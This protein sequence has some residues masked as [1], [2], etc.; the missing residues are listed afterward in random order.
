M[1]NANIEWFL[2]LKP[3]QATSAFHQATRKPFFFESQTEIPTFSLVEIMFPSIIEHP[4]LPSNKATIC[5]YKRDDC[6]SIVFLQLPSC[7][8]NSNFFAMLLDKVLNPKF[9]INLHTAVWRCVY[10]S[11]CSYSE[12]FLE[13]QKRTVLIQWFS[14][15]FYLKAI[16]TLQPPCFTVSVNI[17]C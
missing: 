5:H 12:M 11:E 1:Q 16:M 9:P 3:I 15:F 13:D 10:L 17:Q 4:K 6:C 7:G 2:S 14:I 8:F